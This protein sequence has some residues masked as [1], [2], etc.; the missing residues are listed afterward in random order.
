MAA[1]LARGKANI[2][3][4]TKPTSSARACTRRREEADRKVV[5]RLGQVAEQR[6]VSRAQLALAWLLSKPVITRPLLAP[7]SRIIFRTP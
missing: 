6:G 3:N 7:P 1:W 5:D 4:A 2:P